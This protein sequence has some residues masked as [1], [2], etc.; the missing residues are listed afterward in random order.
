LYGHKRHCGDDAET[1]GA[2]IIAAQQLETDLTLTLVMVN[3][4]GTC[5]TWSLVARLVV[6]NKFMHVEIS[7]EANSTAHTYYH[8]GVSIG[9]DID[10][11][12]PS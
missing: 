10:Q 11:A 6:S 3:S 7:R 1:C 8:S 2:N 5:S 12:Y 9:R 4:K